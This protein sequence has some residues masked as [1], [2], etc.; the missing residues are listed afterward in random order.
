[1]NF[2]DRIRKFEYKLN[3]T[4]DQ[5]VE[6][7][8]AH[9]KMVVDL[10]IQALAAQLFTVPN[11]ITRFTK[12][13]GYDGFSHMK[14]SLKEEISKESIRI[15]NPLLYKINKTVELI[16]TD[17]ME[18][19]TKLLVEANRIIFFGVG[20]TA[21]FCE[22]FVKNLKI[23]GLSAEF[24]V[25]RHEAEL[26][27]KQLQKGDVLFLISLSGETEVVLQMAEIAKN[28]NVTLISLTHF[29]SNTLQKMADVKLYCYSP[30]EF[31]KNRNVTDKTPL[32]IAI[33]SLSEYVWMNTDC[34]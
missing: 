33:Q 27:I 29:D 11:T 14:N 34:V 28:N 10:S 3:D 5:I 7:I 23:A 30:R 2:E 31:F 12:K 8:L 1:M 20:D 22:M 32:M 25:F 17:V 9:K 18:H 21:P 13:V 15:E 24:Y 19:V 26:E 6:Y 16:D 4:D